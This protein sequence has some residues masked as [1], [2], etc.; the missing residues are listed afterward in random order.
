MSYMVERVARAIREKVAERVCSPTTSWHDLDEFRREA[1]RDEARAAIEA[2]R[3]AAESMID[4]GD[5]TNPDGPASARE[6][7]AAMID[8][9]LR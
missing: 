3:N 1:Y 2:M 6:V 8:A 9:A 4:A 7:W 5:L